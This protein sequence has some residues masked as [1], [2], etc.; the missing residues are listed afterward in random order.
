MRENMPDS[1]KCRECSAPFAGNIIL[2][3]MPGSG[4]STVGIILARELCMDFID[5]DVLIQKGEGLPL[6]KIYDRDGADGFLSLE[7]R[8]VGGL[9]TESTVI[10]PGGS[11]VLNKELMA[12]LKKLGHIV[13]L[14]VPIE[15]IIPRIDLSSR[16]TVRKPGE[17]LHDV[18]RYREP[19]YRKSADITVDCGTM[20]QLEIAKKLAQD[21]LKGA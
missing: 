4:K 15:I 6:Q 8:Y 20:S 10:A 13:F 5:T 1:A 19:F 9:A 21:F 18:W 12:R 16:G 3:G 2:T 14:D 11:V 17:T 7:E